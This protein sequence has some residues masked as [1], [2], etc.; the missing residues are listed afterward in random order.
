MSGGMG[1]GD[2]VSVAPLGNLNKTAGDVQMGVPS[3][4]CYYDLTVP[5]KICKDVITQSEIEV[6]VPDFQKPGP[7]SRSVCIQVPTDAKMTKEAYDQAV[8]AAYAKG[9]AQREIVIKRVKK[10]IQNKT[11]Q[12]NIHVPRTPLEFAETENF[13]ITVTTPIRPVISNT[14]CMTMYLVAIWIKPLTA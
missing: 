7:A 10:A 1:G 3:C 5:T 8:A 11:R 6:E 14:I 4:T 9:Q 2:T 12:C 13:T